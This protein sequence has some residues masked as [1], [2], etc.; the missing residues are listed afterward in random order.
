MKIELTNVL[1][2]DY[3]IQVIKKELKFTFEWVVDI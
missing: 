2:C 1:I 3:L